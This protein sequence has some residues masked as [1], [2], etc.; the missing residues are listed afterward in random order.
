MTEP[1]NA[2]L[3]KDFLRAVSD[4]HRS[5]A[6]T[7]ETSHYPAL[8]SLLS[9]LGGLSQP[10]RGALS[11][12]KG[13][14]GDYPDVALYEVRSNVLVLPVEAKGLDRDIAKLAK[15]AQAKR[16]AKTF[17]GGKVLVTNYASFALAELDVASDKLQLI[18]RVDLVASI[19]E[20]SKVTPEPL[21]NAAERLSG[22]L[23]AAC[24]VRGSIS[25]PQ[26]VAQLLAYHGRLMME[27]IQSSASP[28]T[29]LAPIETSFRAGLDMQLEEDMLVPTTV[30]TLVY[31]LFAAWLDDDDPHGFEWIG[32]SYGLSLPVYAD[33]IHAILTPKFVRECNLPARLE[34][35]AR[36][37]SWVDR[38][39]FQS[40]FSGGAIE[41]FFEPFLAEFD[42]HLRDK[43]GVWYTPGSVADY[44][45]AKVQ[46]HL[47]N[48]L[49]IAA[50][51]ASS[52]DDVYVLDPACGTGTY[53]IS[54]LKAVRAYHLANGQPAIVASQLAAEAARS[55][56]I[57]FEI[58]PAAF[59]IAHIN[60]NRVLRDWGVPLQ[61]DERV[62]VYLTNALTGWQVGQEPPLMPL[63]DLEA[64]MRQA[65]EVK[66]SE[67]V[68]VIIGNPPY[69]GFSAAESVAERE[70]LKPWMESL[71]DDYGVRKHRLGDL[72][73]R[74]WRVA[75]QKIA[76]LSDRGIVCFITNRKWLGGR[77]F[78]LMRE[79]LCLSFNDIF[80]D[81]LHGEAHEGIAGDES[82]FKTKTA[83][84]IRVGAAIVT[85][86]RADG[87]K[88][89]RSSPA[90]VGRRDIYGSSASKHQRLADWAREPSIPL[91]AE[92][93]YTA[94]EVS[95]P[96][97]WKLTTSSLS[98]APT[99][100]E[101]MP[102]MFSGVQLLR[103][104]ALTAGNKATLANR[105]R[106][107]F[108]V[109]I[110]DE[111][112]RKKHP[113]F[114]VQRAGY[115]AAKVRHARVA[116]GGFDE[117]HLVRIAYKPMSNRDFFWDTFPGLVHRARPELW[118]HWAPDME[119]RALVV[120]QTARRP[121]AVRPFV[122][123]AVPAFSS[124]DPD[125]RVFPRVLLESDAAHAGSVADQLEG[126]Q[127]LSNPSAGSRVVSGL[128]PDW[129]AAG[130]SVGLTG[131]D[132]EV[133]D[134]LFYALVAVMNSP[135]WVASQGQQLDDFPSVPL[136]S[137]QS[138]LREAAE[139]GRRISLLMDVD[140]P[141][142]GVD[143]GS[144]DPALQEIGVPTDLSNTVTL[145]QGRYGQFGGAFDAELNQ[146]R[147]NSS[148]DES[149]GWSGVPEGVWRFSI[150]GF[151]VVAKHL[152]YM[153]GRSVSV[154]ERLSVMNLCRRIAALEDL[155]EGCNAA[156]EASRHSRLELP[157][158]DGTHADLW[159]Q[160]P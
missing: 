102:K 113:A 139:T 72:Y 7:A 57:G 34:A 148:G 74:F 130:R 32:A 45:V 14:D 145:T 52:S 129:I 126:M 35:A 65:L 87:Q 15:S 69:E 151:P 118:P 123:S 115:N 121:G 25:K 64:E 66:G 127:S 140:N 8:N 12:P 103:D 116:K 144:I 24:A 138:A 67:P 105:I 31:G 22:L 156:Y 53:I 63:D 114:F 26:R 136:P 10:K 101:Y 96:T 91:S 40:A 1:M 47:E 75:I 49:Q 54:V 111:E 122:S 154:N 85:G 159:V 13:I 42:E 21:T 41:Y 77:S 5:G 16:Y 150:G 153:V 146:I 160:V 128:A 143:S 28:A 81:D 19:H 43:L 71:Y 50:G 82:V 152:A 94:V 86:I 11:A 58:L 9:G 23:E 36:M 20:F 95:R 93:D 29:L 88:V 106:D 125:A 3:V 6:G 100:D 97:R 27:E 30:Q 104:D 48:D 4:V 131:N 147:W 83:G 110:S 51:L 44:Q 107:Y 133:G 76:V 62:R 33:M 80:V 155:N 124:M 17:G 2:L 112:L 59:V 37:L 109:S 39:A 142:A 55:R 158:S 90:K 98:D 137:E 78:P 61:K 18:D 38:D 108:D 134:V 46:H 79:S 73:V 120:A 84:G 149:G 60:I 92:D 89:S 117:N 68:I 141:V 135:S 132:V 157:S 56:I 119:Q 99:L 70:L